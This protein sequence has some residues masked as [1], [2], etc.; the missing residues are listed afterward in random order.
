MTKHHT[1][2]SMWVCLSHHHMPCHP[3]ASYRRHKAPDPHQS[4][5]GACS[6]S[7]PKNPSC[8][9]PTSTWCHCPLHSPPTAQRDPRRSCSQELHHSC[10]ASAIQLPTNTSCCHTDGNRTLGRHSCHQLCVIIGLQHF[11]SVIDGHRLDLALI[12]SSSAP[13]IRVIGLGCDSN[14][15]GVIECKRLC[16]PL[17]S[18]STATMTRIWRATD[19][20]LRAQD[21]SCLT[22]GNR[23]VR[24]QSF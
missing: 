22:C 11:E 2:H 1:G 16:G 13:T 3:G 19:N 6:P 15:A 5:S 8:C 14:G 12:A 4:V 10:R 9:A 7:R 17:T 21:G 20:L 24:F 23:Q 18:S